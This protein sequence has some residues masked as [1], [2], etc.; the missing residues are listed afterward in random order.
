MFKHVTND[1]ARNGEIVQFSGYPSLRKH[2][3]LTDFKFIIIGRLHTSDLEFKFHEKII[4][5]I[6][7]FLV[8]NSLS[9]VRALGFDSSNVFIEQMPLGYEGSIPFKLTRRN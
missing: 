4:V 1:M 5:N 3:I 8:H 9:D 7:F 6:Y 2:N